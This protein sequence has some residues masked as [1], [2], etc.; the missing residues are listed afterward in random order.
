MP[1]KNQDF[2]YL[3]IFY[4]ASPETLGVVDKAKNQLPDNFSKRVRV[5]TW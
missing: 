3:E 5:L 1:D 4:Y 2:R